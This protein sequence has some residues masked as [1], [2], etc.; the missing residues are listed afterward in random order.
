MFAEYRLMREYEAETD[1]QRR[2]ARWVKA[3]LRLLGTLR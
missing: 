2:M 1:N 3:M